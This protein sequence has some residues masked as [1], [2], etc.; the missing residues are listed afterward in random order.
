[1]E[2]KIYTKNVD[3]NPEVESYIQ[4]KFQ[5]LERHLKPLSDAKLEISR[6][7]ARSQEDR[8]NAQ[9]TLTTKGNVL[10]GQKRGLNLYSAIDAVADVMDR[11][12]RRFK[13]KVYR[14]EQGRRGGKAASVPEGAFPEDVDD[15]VVVDSEADEPKV[16][17]RKRFA[18]KPMTPEEAIDEMELLSHSFFLSYNIDSSEFNVV[19]RRHDG[20]YS[21]IEPDLV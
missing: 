17:R 14:S 1:M 15:A 11:Q 4:K 5:R 3:L 7:S 16:L 13:G 9:M 20:D 2:L 19:Y 21:V 10:R 6:T 12:I 18:M 8:I